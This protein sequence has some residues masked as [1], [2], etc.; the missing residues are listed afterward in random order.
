VAMKTEEGRA[1]GFSSGL[2][3]GKRS[4]LLSCQQEVEEVAIPLR[5]NVFTS[6]R[7]VRRLQERIAFLEAKLEEA[8]A[9]VKKS[10]KE[11]DQLT[12]FLI[13]ARQPASC[14]RRSTIPPQ[15]EDGPDISWFIIDDDS[16]EWEEDRAKKRAAE[17]S[18]FKR[19]AGLISNVFGP[20][21]RNTSV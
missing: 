4:G 2:A 1:A 15:F 20:D 7:E 21:S 18:A 17:P 16:S 12:S 10:R 6:S 8:E 19:V 14:R 13:E 11:A 5:E 9:S 3:L